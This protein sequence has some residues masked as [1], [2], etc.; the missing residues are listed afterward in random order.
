MWLLMII[1]HT[2][3]ATVAFGTGLGVLSPARV[4]RHDW[5]LPVFLGCLAGMTVFVVGAIA[6]HWS[7]LSGLTRA[8]YAGLVALA[9]FMLYRG[10]RAYTAFTSQ[11]FDSGRYVDDVG[12][13][14]ISLFDG[15]VIV[16]AI[17]LGAPGWLVGVVAVVSV[18]AGVQ[19]L[20]QAKARV[21]RAST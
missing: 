17:D 2:I 9:I 15:F 6:F 21:M 7:D 10:A 8:V 16:L 3:A 14:L 1:L 11:A 18:V 4:R 19:L 12:F 5:L 20:H 13:V